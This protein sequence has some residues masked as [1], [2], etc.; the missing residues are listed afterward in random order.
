MSKN[1]ASPTLTSMPRIIRKALYQRLAE[2]PELRTFQ[3]DFEITTGL[4]LRFVDELGL[5]PPCTA[6]ANALCRAILA[7]EAGARLCARARH[8][9]LEKA[10]DEACATTCDAGLVEAAVPV[11]VGRITVGFF[12]LG[13]VMKDRPSTA[14]LHKTVHLL[15]KAGLR[16]PEE[17]IAS[18]R[19]RS[20]HVSEDFV[21]AVLRMVAAAARQ[22]AANETERLTTSNHELPPPVAAACRHI[23]QYAVS[24]NLRFPELAKKCGAS[25]GHLSRLFHKSTGLTVPEYIGRIRADRARE[26]LLASSKTITEIAFDSGFQS[27]SQFQRVF[28]SVHGCTPRALRK[29]SQTSPD[30]V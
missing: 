11:R 25:T 29:T 7:D 15:R 8:G 3:R 24:T 27:L 12:L 30:P 21:E 20:R 1:T 6:P 17:T 10:R 26:L 16:I 19:R 2:S 4:Q 18:L 28:K 13:G 23:R 22:I 14:N 9:L 5:A